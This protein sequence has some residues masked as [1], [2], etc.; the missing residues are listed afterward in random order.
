[1]IVE[2]HAFAGDA[3]R[4]IACSRAVLVKGLF[5]VEFAVAIVAVPFWQ[6]DLTSLAILSL[7]GRLMLKLTVLVVTAVESVLNQSTL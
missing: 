7:T 4:V 2:E 1:M 5:A 6:L 3:V